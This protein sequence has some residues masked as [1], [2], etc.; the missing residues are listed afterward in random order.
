MNPATVFML[1]TNPDYAMLLA[2]YFYGIQFDLVHAFFTM[3]FLGLAARPILD[4][5][6]RVKEKYGILG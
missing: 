6:N 4:K 2:A 3:V 5:L 1:Q